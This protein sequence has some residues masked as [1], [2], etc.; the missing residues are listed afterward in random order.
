[1]RLNRIVIASLITFILSCGQSYSAGASARG[2]IVDFESDA[3]ILRNAEIVEYMDRKCLIGTAFLKDVEFE[4]GVIEVDVAVDGARSYPGIVFRMQSE[5]NYE[6]FYLRPHRSNLYPDALQYT[7]VINGIACWQFY[8]GAGYTAGAD[9]PKDQWMHLKM[10]VQG[11]QARIF[12]NDTSKPVLEI[13]DLKHGASRGTIGIFSPRNR[14]AHFSNFRYQI[15][16]SLQFDKP[17]KIETPPGMVMEW[18]LSQAVKYS[19]IETER[20]PKEELEKAEW[21]EVSADPS[22]LINVASYIVRTSREPD[23]VMA[24]TVIKSDESETKK[25]LFGYSDEITVFLNGDILFTGESAYQ[26]RDPSFLGIVGLYD[27]VYLPLKKGDNE[28]LLMISEVFGG[29]GFMCQDASA[30]FQ[31]ADLEKRWETSSDFMIPESAVYDSERNVFYVS[32][33]DMYNNSGPTGTQFISKVSAEGKIEKLKWVEGLGK[34]T[35]MAIF[36]DKL[37]VVERRGLAEVDL[38]SGEVLERHQTPNSIFLNDIAIDQSG[39]AYISDSSKG[40]IYRFSE[41][42]FEEWLSGDQ[43]GAPNGLHI[44]DGNLIIGNSADN[45]LK[46]A[47]LDTKEVTTIANLGSGIIDGIRT[48][49]N[50]NYIVSHW[51]GR[52]YRVSQTG[53]VTRLLDVTPSR[54]YCADFEYVVEKDLMIV[55]AFFNNRLTAYQLTD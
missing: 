53:Q 19:Q 33:Y 47:D 48:D 41:G 43:I 21:Q 25:Y 4:D 45:R 36:R 28:L 5:Q 12:I 32:N 34:P 20:Y 22:G 10:E 8:N 6:R 30:I 50:G 13:Y 3:W 16:N 14:T 38:A 37:Y 40:V 15:D 49:K 23:C 1:M 7:P 18:W 27:A 44:Y 29:W 35:G 54:C 17:P 46:A 39:Q 52:I 42:E 26:Q 9:I 55:P 51:E 11:T 2:E 31:H 24:K